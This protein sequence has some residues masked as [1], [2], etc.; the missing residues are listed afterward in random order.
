MLIVG[1]KFSACETGP[2]WHDPLRKQEIPTIDAMLG[3]DV[4]ILHDDFGM[5]LDGGPPI[6]KYV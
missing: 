5:A 2:E 6:S 3:S 4:P 1:P